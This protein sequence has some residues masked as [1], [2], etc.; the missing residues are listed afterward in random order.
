MSIG[1]TV[2]TAVAA[3]DRSV[4]PENTEGA[5]VLRIAVP[6]KGALSEPAA[7]LL[8]EAGYRRRGTQKELVL[9]DEPNGVELFFLRPRDIAVYVGSG[10][11]DIGIT[12]Q[13]MLLDSRT[14]ATTLLELGF[15]RSTFRFAAV[16]GQGRAL[17]ELDGARIAT[18]YENLLED[19]LTGHG[20]HAEV[21]HLDGA[22]ESSIR[23]GV[24]DVIA[25]VVETGTT[26]RQ[27][28][29]EVFGE[30]IVTSQAVLFQ[31]PGLSLDEDAQRTLDVMIRRLKGVLV[32]RQYVLID[33]DIPTE[34][35]EQ[36]VAVTPGFQAPTVSPLH[37][38]T[39]SAVR[40]MVPRVDTNTVMDGL[41]EA[42]ARAILVTAIQACRI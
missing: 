20:V 37:G 25:D 5:P 11:V 28:G 35:L 2:P 19:Y 42:G 3:R 38:G 17:A 10:T 16:A 26:L 21:V 30:P 13:D 36:A 39:W 6:N 32:A 23:L 1:R 15:A 7:D 8:S 9:V 29:L 41:Y 24:A 31:R 27:A 40:S 14:E 4:R 12:G 33:Y 22:V 18:S 34:K